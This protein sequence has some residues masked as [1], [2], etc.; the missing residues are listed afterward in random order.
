MAVD[1]KIEAIRCLSRGDAGDVAV[2]HGLLQ[3]AFGSTPLE[4]RPPPIC[5]W[6]M[7]HIGVDIDARHQSAAEAETAGYRIVV[8]PVLRCFRS[9]EGFDPI[10]A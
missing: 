6:L 10:R 1:T 7:R 3:A 8:D 2:V 4:P 5:D 9:V